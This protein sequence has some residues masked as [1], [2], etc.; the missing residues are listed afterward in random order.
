MEETIKLSGRELDV[1]N[2]LWGINVPVIAK[3]IVDLDPSL[4]INT[5]Q[6]ILKSLLKRK[7]IK[8][9]DIVY[10]GK[11]LTRSYEAVLTA[12]EYMLKQISKGINTK[13]ITTEGIVAALFNMEE[14]EDETLD[15]LEKILKQRRRELKKGE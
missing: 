1:M 4:S 9:A 14:I 15:R 7:Y 12:D 11:V 3:E 13:R 6:A 8:V 2:V 5:V 10:S